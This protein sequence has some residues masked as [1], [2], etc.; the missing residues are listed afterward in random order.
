M[1]PTTK[2]PKLVIA[3]ETVRTMRLRTGLKTG[4]LNGCSLYITCS[5]HS[6]VGSMTQVPPSD[7]MA[8]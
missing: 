2:T 3:K 1:K 8:C 5:C 6:E 4:S 7:R